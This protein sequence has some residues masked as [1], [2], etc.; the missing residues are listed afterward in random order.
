MYASTERRG[1]FRDPDGNPPPRSCQPQNMFVWS[2]STSARMLPI[3]PGDMRSKMCQQF[4][5]V[6]PVERPFSTGR[7]KFHSRDT[8]S[9]PFLFGVFW[10]RGTAFD[11]RH[12]L[13]PYV[14]FHPD[15]ML[16]GRRHSLCCVLA[17]PLQ[18]EV[19]NVGHI[20]TLDNEMVMRRV[21]T[22]GRP[23]ECLD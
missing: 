12:R 5:T 11:N 19:R 15:L 14:N 9:S 18:I 22:R 4:V 13:S 17:N 10:P 3:G 1:T 21:E 6:G 20:E 8:L 7:V 16:K 2:R 23:L